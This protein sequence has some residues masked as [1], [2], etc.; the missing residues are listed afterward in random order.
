MPTTYV[1]YSYSPD[2]DAQPGYDGRFKPFW[3][4]EELEVV[5]GPVQVRCSCA[6]FGF[7]TT[8]TL[9]RGAPQ[10]ESAISRRRLP[11]LVLGRL[12]AG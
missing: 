8:A 5:D 10:V 3:H 7:S 2:S 9:Y 11:G 6:D 12:S 4:N 1:L